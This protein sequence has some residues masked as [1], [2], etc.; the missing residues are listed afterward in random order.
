MRLVPAVLLALP[1]F[2]VAHSQEPP[3]K[4]AFRDDR[5]GLAFTDIPGFE[6]GDV[7]RYD[8][9]ALGYSVGYSSKLGMGVTI[10]VYTFAVPDIPDGP[11]SAE[12]RGQ[13]E[14][15]TRDILK[16]KSDGT[17]QKVEELAHEVVVLGEDAAAPKMRKAAF[18]TRYKDTDLV[19]YVYVTGH[20]GHFVKVRASMRASNQAACEK[21]ASQILRRLGQMLRP[22][23]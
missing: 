19:S 7:H 3:G 18:K 13:I 21:A 8:N 12:V 9:P 11:F 10:Y 20:R 15:A 16:K 6:R 14:Q 17:Y 4:P 5:T 23:K 2:S 22:E 1:L